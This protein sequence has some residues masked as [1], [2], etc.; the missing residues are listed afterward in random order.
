MPGEGYTQEQLFEVV[1]QAKE[2]KADVI[3]DGY[4]FTW[5]NGYW[6]KSALKR[7]EREEA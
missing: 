6:R 1:E 7:T 2:D 5:V 3:V 4:K